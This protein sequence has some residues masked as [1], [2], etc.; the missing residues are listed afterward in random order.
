MIKKKSHKQ[1][2]LNQHHKWT[3]RR[4]SVK[5]KT[6]T[7]I[8]KSLWRFVK[9]QWQSTRKRSTR[10]LRINS[11]HWSNAPMITYQTTNKNCKST[12]Q[13]HSVI[14]LGKRISWCIDSIS[15]SLLKCVSSHHL[16][17]TRMQFH[18]GIIT[19]I[20]TCMDKKAIKINFTYLQTLLSKKSSLSV[21]IVN[22]QVQ[23]SNSMLRW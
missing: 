5:Y 19:L 6:N 3:K 18:N 23:P 22:S 1:H 20:C 2:L 4:Q 14:I 10:S 16:L 8:L 17:K 12:M 21:S 7:M 13:A 15:N 11:N 9:N